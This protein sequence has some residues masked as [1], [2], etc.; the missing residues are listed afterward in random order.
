[1]KRNVARTAIKIEST[2]PEKMV[3]QCRSFVGNVASANQRKKTQLE[4]SK[5]GL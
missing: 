2:A 5:E 3:A 4:P 1:M